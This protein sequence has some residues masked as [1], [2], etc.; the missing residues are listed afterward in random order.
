MI[1]EVVVVGPLQC[2]CSVLGDEET[3]EAIVIDPGDEVE[4]I[5]AVLKQHNLKARYIVNTHAHFDHVGNCCD[6]KEATGAEI[7]LHKADL[8]IYETAPRQ[9]ALFSLYGVRP[10]RMTA[11]DQ[12]LKDADGLQVGKI[13]AQALH[14]PGHTPGSLSLNVP[15]DLRDILF[16]GDT[17]F[18]GSIGR[19]DLPGGDLH[20]LLKSIK[21][22]ML[23]LDDATEVWPGHGPKTTIGRER[24]T[25]PFLQGL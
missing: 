19:T 5:L 21:D 18:S 7:W 22:R 14:T 15:G 25:N 17:L 6:L 4:R 12:Y 11:V 23:T 24:R 9:A 10:I 2:N 20:R 13:A 16:A 3:R 1:H 8:P